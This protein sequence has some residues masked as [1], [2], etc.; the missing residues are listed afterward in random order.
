[1]NSFNQK[2]K[3]ILKTNKEYVD[4][5]NN[6]LKE[7]I[8]DDSLK[9]AKKLIKLLIKDEE[10]LNVF[11]EDVEGCKVFNYNKFNDYIDKK[12]FLS[13]S[14]TKFKNRIGL[15]INNKYLDEVDNVSL[16]WPFKDCILEGGMNKEDMKRNEIFFNETLARDEID[17][18]FDEKV[19]NNFK[20][21]S[22]KGEESLEKFRKDNGNI[23]KDNLI[24]NG[25]NLL[26]LSSIKN[27]FKRKIKLIYIDPPFNTDNDSFR[28]N[29]SFNHSTWL[30]F[31]KNRLNISKELLREDGLIF[32]HIDNNEEA[33]LKV[34]MDEIFGR[35][36]FINIISVKSSSPSGVKTSHRDRTILKSQDFILVYAI[37][38]ENIILK[39]QYMKKEK[40]D[41]HYCFF[42]E[43][44]IHGLEL[45]KL[46]DKLIDENLLNIDE[47]LNSFDINNKKH[48]KFY[49][50]N[51]NSIVRKSTHDNKEIKK[52][53]EKEY[54]DQIYDQDGNFYLNKDML[55]PVSKSFQT[56][57]DGLEIRKD[58]SNLLCDMW[59]DIDFQN[60]QNQGNVSFP[61]GKK[62]EQ[63]LYR[64]I[65]MATNEDDIILD[66]YSGSG[67]TVAVA[68]KMKRQYITIEQMDYGENSAMIRLKK[69]IGDEKNGKIVNYDNKGMSES[70]NWKGGGNFI[71]FEL[72]KYNEDAIFKIQSAKSNEDLL[73]LWEEM[74]EN[75]FLNYDVDINKFNENTDDF[76]KLKLKE[77]KNLLCEMLNK[78][79]LYVNLSEI[80]D[81]EFNISDEVKNLN[82][83]F[84]DDYNV[85]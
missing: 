47:S 61:K 81:A 48:R 45:I 71:Y 56:V 3:D 41:T 43:K 28:Y 64:I 72:M 85:G 14:Y 6:L 79:Q 11:F 26:A 29:D 4:E 33:Y 80:D 20:K 59:T 34:L 1:L 19:L 78:N 57:L 74:C 2:L 62:P 21:I 15:N 76:R 35:D 77:Q 23:I 27:Q 39:P 75:Y 67:T 16:V 82:K 68:H 69:V 17:R 44:T 13:N 42:I 38:K 60:T 18:L 52:K 12:N 22:S 31:M 10:F 73:N 5:D 58:L 24:I 7:K 9:Q 37:N 50:D 63:L 49:M 55:Q 40:W 84:Y 53:C 83:S 54:K 70:L 46:K 51:G 66:F 32:V 30:T 8:I 65:D 25:N 36:N